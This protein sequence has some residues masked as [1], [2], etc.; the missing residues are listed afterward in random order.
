MRITKAPEIRRQEMIGTAAR[1]FEKNGISKTSMAQIARHLN[2]AKSL[3]YYYFDSKENLVAAV[4]D[5]LTS[6]LDVAL[7]KITKDRQLDF[8]AKLKAILLFYFNAIQANPTILSLAPSDPGVFALLRD[9]LSNIAF[10]HVHDII[11]TG[12][13]QKII[14][15]AHP[16]HML[17]ILIRGLGDLYIDG[18]RDPVIHATLIEQTLGLACGSLSD[19]PAITTGG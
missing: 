6:D 15:I 7:D 3:V 4:V 9:A 17:K 14:A 1:L 12:L 16:E 13:D 19:Q 11:R 18:M 8:H 2:V 10:L 5:Q